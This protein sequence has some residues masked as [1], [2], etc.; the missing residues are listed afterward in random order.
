MYSG[1]KKLAPKKTPYQSFSNL[2]LRAHFG[3]L[4]F[5]TCMTIARLKLLHKILTL[6]IPWISAILQLSLGNPNSWAAMVKKDWEW[7]RTFGLDD[8]PQLHQHNDLFFV[9]SSMS[10]QKWK[11]TLQLAKSRVLGLQRIAADREELRGF[12]RKCFSNVGLETTVGYSGQW[13]CVV[14]DKAF[15]SFQGV[16]RHE[17]SVH[18]FICVSNAFADGAFCR[19]C[20]QS[21]PTTKHVGQTPQS[22]CRMLGTAPQNLSGWI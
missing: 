9:L 5:D 4:P 19:M 3:I 2:R 11:R 6:Q 22:A 17:A 15:D 13:H 18:G 21:F 8:L 10:P 16:R 14:C 1:L 20:L 12:Q 7:V